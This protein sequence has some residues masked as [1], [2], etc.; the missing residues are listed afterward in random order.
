[1]KLQTL[2]VGKKEEQKEEYEE[3]KKEETMC[4][5]NCPCLSPPELLLFANSSAGSVM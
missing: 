2:E 3:E 1:M 5:P 4:T